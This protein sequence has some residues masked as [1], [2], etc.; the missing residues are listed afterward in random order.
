MCSALPLNVVQH[1]QKSPENKFL[2]TPLTVISR[3]LSNRSILKRYN[4][5]RGMRDEF[6]FADEM[7]E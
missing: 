3:H 5:A 6:N 4:K 2:P 1:L 7:V